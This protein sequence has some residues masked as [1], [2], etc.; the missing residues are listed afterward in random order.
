LRNFDVSGPV[1]EVFVQVLISL[2][3]R[4]DATGTHRI[5]YANSFDVS[6]LSEPSPSHNIL[7]KST[8]PSAILYLFENSTPPSSSVWISPCSHRM[9]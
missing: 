7:L 6:E 5:G 1:L 4:G 2:I 9:H 3:I 8:S